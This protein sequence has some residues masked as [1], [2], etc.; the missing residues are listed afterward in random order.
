[1]RRSAEGSSLKFLRYLYLGIAAGHCR[2]NR[3]HDVGDMR[4]D[5]TPVIRAQHHQ[6]DCPSC[7]I[8]LVPQPLIRGDE[9]T[10][11]RFFCSIEQRSVLQARLT[12]K[13]RRRNRVI[14]HDK[15]PQLLRD[16]FVK[17]NFHPARKVS[18]GGWAL[19]AAK[20]NTV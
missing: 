4:L 16:A 5:E 20:S 15:Q 19:F 10:E 9:Q 18:R 6:R 1:M 17:K 3:S 7:Q 11:A 8:L 13:P 2:I 14:S 12:L